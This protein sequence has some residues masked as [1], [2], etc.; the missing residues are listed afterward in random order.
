MVSAID[1]RRYTAQEVARAYDRR[2]RIYSR[3]IAPLEHAE[4]LLAIEAADVRSGERI[5]EVAIGPGL[6]LAELARC[7]GPDAPVFGVDISRG[8]LRLAG[9]HLRAA[10]VANA[11]LIAADARNLPFKDA[12]FDLL[13]NGYMLDLIP[14]DDMGQLLEE[15]ERVLV[16]GGRMV[17]LNMSK[18]R[19]STTLRQRLYEVLPAQ[20]VLYLMGGCR[21]VMME[22]R[23]R[24]AG[25]EDV[26]RAF[27]PG[28][29][30]SEIVLA[31]K[32]SAG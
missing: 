9:E 1:A 10:A 21:P 16:P 24:E 28:R 4:H 15:F 17:L 30:P 18:D 13:Y 8:M 20:L 27:L 2:G 29:F 14:F 7:V 12:S 31:R 6:T 5:L 26:S 3:T 11:V 22:G 23:V 32:R 25:F 19:G